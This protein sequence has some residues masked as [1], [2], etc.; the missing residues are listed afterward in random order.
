MDQPSGHF[1]PVEEPR[2]NLTGDIFFT[3]GRRAVML[4]SAEPVDYEDIDMFHWSL[5]P[6]GDS[7]PDNN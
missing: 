2:G 7:A 6:P 3:D 5:P 4:L 1:A